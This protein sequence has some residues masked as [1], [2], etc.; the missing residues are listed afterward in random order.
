[1]TDDP[2]KQDKA[3]PKG[4][5]EIDEEVLDAVAGGLNNKNPD[6]LSLQVDTSNIDIA[7]QNVSQQGLAGAGPGAGPHVV[8]GKKI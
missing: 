2:G 4:A 6:L 5:V 7:V 3:A 8:P 1:M